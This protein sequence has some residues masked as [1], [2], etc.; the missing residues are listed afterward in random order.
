MC[1]LG[2]VPREEYPRRNDNKA[3]NL[4]IRSFLVYGVGIW[5]AVVVGY[6]GYEIDFGSSIYFSSK[7]R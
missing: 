3:A 4:L 6:L 2:E 5:I 1:V 7:L